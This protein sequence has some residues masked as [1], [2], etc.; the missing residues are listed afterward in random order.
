MEEFPAPHSTDK[1]SIFAPGPFI[2]TH[3]PLSISI[4]NP[5]S[6]F[7]LHI[8]PDSSTPLPFLMLYFFCPDSLFFLHVKVLPCPQRSILP[9]ARLVMF[10]QAHSSRQPSVTV[11]A[12]SWSVPPLSHKPYIS[13][14]LLRKYLPKYLKNAVHGVI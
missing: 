2:P 5:Y 9:R 12:I 11:F 1:A 13:P 6:R 4:T 14:V 3:S 7:R 10:I 8:F